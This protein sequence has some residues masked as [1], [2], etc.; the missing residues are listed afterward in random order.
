MLP[1]RPAWL[2]ISLTQSPPSFPY[3][4][5]QEKAGAGSPAKARLPMFRETIV[6]VI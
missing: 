6:V 1:E 5:E 2:A 3:T 4:S